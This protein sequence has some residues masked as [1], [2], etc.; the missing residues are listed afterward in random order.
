MP[1][2]AVTAALGAGSYSYQVSYSGD[3]NYAARTTAC[4]PFTVAKAVPEVVSVVDDAS[5]GAAWLNTQQAGAS[6]QDTSSIGGVSGFTPTGSV[7]YALYGDESCTGAALMTL[8]V[9]INPD[10]TVPRS[11]PTAALAAGSYGYQ[12]AYSGDGNY[13]AATAN[14][15][16][17]TVASSSSG[18]GSGPSPGGGSGP[19]PGGGSGPALGGRAR[20]VPFVVSRITSRR[21]GVVKFHLTVQHAGVV[22]VLETAWDNNLASVAN[23]VLLNPAPHRFSFARLHLA[24]RRPRTVLVTVRPNARGRRL[25]AHHRYPVLIRLWVT[26]SV[27]GHPQG[28]QGFYGIPLSRKVRQ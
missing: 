23:V 4:E 21:S 6:A 2:S 17:F 8:R 20:P 5:T 18:G 16:P 3:A 27:S 26:Y 25:M 22:N 14:C 13:S 24:V 12:A 28:K 19:S 1:A 15:E 7:T 10:G 11:T 9:A